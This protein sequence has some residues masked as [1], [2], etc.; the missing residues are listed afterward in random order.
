MA[1]PL[2]MV[3]PFQL[4]N[5]SCRIQTLTAEAIELLRTVGSV[6]HQYSTRKFYR[7]DVRLAHCVLLQRNGGAL[8]VEAAL[9]TMIKGELDDAGKGINVRRKADELAKRFPDIELS[10]IASAVEGAPSVCGGRQMATAIASELRRRATVGV[11]TWP[12][13]QIVRHPYA[14]QFP[15]AVTVTRFDDQWSVEVSED[16]VIMQRLFDRPEFASEFEARQRA[17]LG[18]TRPARN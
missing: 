14:G 16:G 1:I 5:V 6:L 3:T 17:R 4:F 8:L 2:R 7:P 13:L 18:L 12:P 11:R 10:A 9:Y 15:N